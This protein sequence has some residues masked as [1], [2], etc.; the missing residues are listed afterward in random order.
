MTFSWASAIVGFLFA[1]L[2]SIGA[3]L[4]WRQ[5]VRTRIPAP[6]TLLVVTPP[7][8]WTHGLWMTDA[9]GHSHWVT[10]HTPLVVVGCAP[11]SMVMLHKRT[12]SFDKPATR[13]NGLL[14]CPA[15]E[16]LRWTRPLGSAADLAARRDVYMERGDG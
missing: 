2:A 8:E 3:M 9:D 7:N 11:R 15:A 6:D 1:M 5:W 10:E 13:F 14:F 12:P 16:L 4:S